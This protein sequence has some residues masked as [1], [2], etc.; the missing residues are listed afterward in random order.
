MDDIKTSLLNQ[1]KIKIPNPLLKW[2]H[3]KCS[4]NL[5]RLEYAL[6]ENR[7]RIETISPMKSPNLIETKSTNLIFLTNE[8]SNNN[9]GFLFLKELKLW[10]VDLYDKYSTNCM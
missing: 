3:I 7:F 8:N 10:N 6:G 4:V 5:K 2:N 1:E 9:Y